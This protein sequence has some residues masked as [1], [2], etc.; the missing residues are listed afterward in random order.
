M[1]HT[2][3]VAKFLEDPINEAAWSLFERESPSECENVLFHYTSLGGLLGILDSG[4]LWATESRYL[5]DPTEITYADRIILSVIDSIK[6]SCDPKF[7]AIFAALT[8][9]WE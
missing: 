6:P 4:A 9:L 7:H 2:E 5:N 3:M 1:K 8:P